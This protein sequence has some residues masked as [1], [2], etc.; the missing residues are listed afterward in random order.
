MENKVNFLVR[1][2][3]FQTF[4]PNYLAEIPPAVAKAAHGKWKVAKKPPS[5]D[6]DTYKEE[7]LL[8]FR[9]RQ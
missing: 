2:I 6:W 5:E 8:A 9:Q 4:D 1:S 3:S 7:L